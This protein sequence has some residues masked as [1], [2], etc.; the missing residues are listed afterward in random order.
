MRLWARTLSC[1][2]SSF[3][4]DG[5]I[6]RARSCAC[7]CDDDLAEQLALHE[8][9]ERLAGFLEREDPVDDGAQPR[10]GDR[11]VHGLE[12]GPAPHEDA[13]DRRHARRPGPAGDLDRGL[14]GAPRNEEDDLAV[15][16]GGPHR[17]LDGVEPY[18]TRGFD[19]RATRGGSFEMS[20]RD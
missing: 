9:M 8:V 10:R 4:R 7:P 20:S 1:C 15:E 16:G 19:P 11:P 18:R 2:R 17:L 6:P 13:A 5:S 14:G 3:P 12:A